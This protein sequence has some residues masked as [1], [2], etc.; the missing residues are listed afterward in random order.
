MCLKFV[1]GAVAFNT[2]VVDPQIGCKETKKL[3]NIKANVSG[4]LFLDVFLQDRG[5]GMYCCHSFIF[6]A[7]HKMIC[8]V[9]NF[10]LV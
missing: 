8:I 7:H 2:P 5:R 10:V 3:L 6:F 4:H 9:A 1:Y